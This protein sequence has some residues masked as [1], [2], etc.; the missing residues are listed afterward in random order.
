MIYIRGLLN[1]FVRLA[2]IHEINITKKN[3]TQSIDSLNPRVFWKD[4]PIILGQ[5]NKWKISKIKTTIDELTNAEILIKSSTDI[6]GSEITKKL[7]I[8]ICNKASSVA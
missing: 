1:Q 7:L 5:A 2:E 6:R 4:K 8:D 3:L